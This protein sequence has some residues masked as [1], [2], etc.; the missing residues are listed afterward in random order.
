MSKNLVIAVVLIAVGITLRFNAHSMAWP[1]PGSGYSY[2]GP[3][4]DTQWGVQE[5][6]I[7]EIGRGCFYLGG[8]LLVGIVLIPLF[9]NTEREDPN[10]ASEGIPRKLG[11][12]QG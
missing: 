6:A 5:S 1:R 9:R 2:S 3:A 12:P 4:A 7:N 8:V 10:Q 11:N